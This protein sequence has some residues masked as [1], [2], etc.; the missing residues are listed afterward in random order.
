MTVRSPGREAPH[1]CAR[2][3]LKVAV[4]VWVVDDDGR[5]P[6]RYLAF[7][8]DSVFFPARDS[9]HGSELWARRVR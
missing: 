9:E 4:A 3:V 2:G 8:G 5:F 6:K 1:V 7:N